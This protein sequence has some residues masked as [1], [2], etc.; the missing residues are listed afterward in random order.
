MVRNRPYAKIVAWKNL[1]NIWMELLLISGKTVRSLYSAYFR[2]T[3]IRCCSYTCC[4]QWFVK[5]LYKINV[6]EFTKDNINVAP[7]C[8]SHNVAMSFIHI[9]VY[10]T[11]V[12]HATIQKL[13]ELLLSKCMK[14][15]SHFVKKRGV[16]QKDLWRDGVHLVGSGKVTANPLMKHP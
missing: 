10:C 7:R 2:G 14:F 16:C 15:G 8:Q 13:D 4:N 6:N 9:I 5:R 12:S 3:R 1:I 11:E